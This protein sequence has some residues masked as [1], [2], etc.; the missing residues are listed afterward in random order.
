[1]TC[2]FHLRLQTKRA[3]VQ[4]LHSFIY[5]FTGLAI[6][7]KGIKTPLTRILSLP[8]YKISS[9]TAF[10]FIIFQTYWFLL[11]LGQ[12]KL[13]LWCI[14][15]VSSVFSP[16]IFPQLSLHE[17]SNI[18]LL[19]F[20]D[21]DLMYYADT[22]ILYSYYLSCQSIFILFSHRICLL[23]SA[24]QVPL[25]VFGSHMDSLNINLS[26][27]FICLLS[28]SSHQNLLFMKAE[29]FFSPVLELCLEESNT[30]I[31]SIIIC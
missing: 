7:K 22:F 29:I 30:S 2:R 24:I 19:F 28:S 13:I 12:A 26:Q 25:T 3:N 5:S 18:S 27:V 17:H 31:I 8:T 9:S 6:C 4:T 14:W 20:P 23:T 10:P 21:H 15:T 16:Q 1:M 11:S